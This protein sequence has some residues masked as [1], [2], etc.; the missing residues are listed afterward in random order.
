MRAIAI[1][2]VLAIAFAFTGCAGTVP[3][4]QERADQVFG[5]AKVAYVI[6]SLG[7]AVYNQLTPCGQNGAQPPLCYSERVG[8]L[9]D[10]SMAGAALAIKGAEDIFAAA[11]TDE[12]ARL[13]AANVAKA[14][15]ESL[16]AALRQFGLSGLGQ[17]PA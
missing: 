9:L 7:V 13:K 16:M 3:D 17:G 11:N 14:V 1:L 8:E 10:K 4:R 12:D 15:V 2:A 5:T 6:A